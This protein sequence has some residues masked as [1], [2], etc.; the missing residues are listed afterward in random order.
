MRGRAT[1]RT[2]DRIMSLVDRA[3][4]LRFGAG[5]LLALAVASGCAAQAHY[6]KYPRSPSTA[7]QEHQAT[8]LGRIFD[9]AAAKHPGES[10]VLFMRY[11]RQA[12]EAR[13]ALADLAERSLDLQYYIWDPDVTGH[14]LADRIIRA[15]DRGVHVRVLLD[16]HGIAGRDNAIA[17]LSAHPN[18]EIR[19]F[20]P[21]RN[22]GN[23]LMDFITD[24]SSANRRSH[25]KAMIADNAIVI[26]GGRNI[27]DSYFGVHGE[28]NFRDLDVVAVGP[29]VRDASAVFDDFWNS[30][31]AIP[32]AAFVDKAPT[33]AEADAAIAE[34]RAT[35][36]KE[37]LP[38][39][40][41]QEVSALTA[42]LKA[43]RDRLTWAPVRVL[44][45][46]PE[47]AHDPSSRRIYDELDRLISNAHQ[48]VLI[49]NAYF[50]PRDYG[51][52][53]VGGLH[54]RGVRVRVLTNSLASND[55]LAVHSGYQK[56]R[57][58]MIENGVEIYELR[59]D[60][61]M[62]QL[63][64]SS[65]SEESRA[66]LHAKAMIIDRRYVVIGSY[67]L[68]PRS[69]DINTELALLVDS[70]KFAE[71]VVEVFDDGVKPEN[72]Y[73]VTLEGGKLK[74]TTSDGGKARVYTEEP[75]TSWWQRFKADAM[76][77]LPIHSML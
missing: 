11:G 57:G 32:Y 8:T 73:R 71:M 19:A 52:E 65:V 26:V 45:D 64:W 62:E 46:S 54:A 41:D 5:A 17:R 13:L 61:T 33:R 15:A 4:R 10:G 23:R 51:V 58:D 35:M 55:L 66:G 27:A 56:Y 47:K 48:E 68:D 76:G 7:F 31:F 42:D 40:I 60:A 9:P 34:M 50:V 14:M 20:N 25:N 18:I 30:Q 70:P 77:L 74:W 63:R 28:S 16:D 36:A 53:L 37:R 67:N 69:A 29:V 49:E 75:E 2:E 1:H 39:P 38:Y 22:R 3:S 44:Y 43:V 21:F 12:L 24:P 6:A 72:S 59:P